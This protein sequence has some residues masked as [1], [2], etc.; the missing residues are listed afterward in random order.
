MNHSETSKNLEHDSPTHYIDRIEKIATFLKQRIQEKSH[1]VPRVAAILGS[2]LGYAI[3]AL[4]NKI[5][6]SF[7]EIPTLKPSTLEG[8]FKKLVFGTYKNKPIALV[9]GRLH[10]YEGYSAKEVVLLPYALKKIGVE[11]L[12]L[13]NAAGG[14]SASLVPGDLVLIEDQINL[15]GLH[16][17]FGPHHPELGP[18]FLDS[19]QLYSETLT[20]LFEKT[21]QDLGKTLKRGVYLGLSGPSFETPAEVR[22]YRAFGA[23]MVGMSTVLEAIAANGVGLKV[24]GISLITNV[25][26]GERKTT[27]VTTHQEVLDQAKTSGEFFSKLLLEG[28]NKI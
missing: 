3:D 8:H 10:A 25:H 23:D 11:A 16:P 15:S 17:T 21:A 19:S 27:A 2:G 24:A 22:M 26:S 5:E 13:T 6:I 28:L 1:S 20:A 14:V 18:R 12:V 9:A 4:E 7:Q